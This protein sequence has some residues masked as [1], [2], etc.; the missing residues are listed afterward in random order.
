[1]TLISLNLVEFHV[2]RLPNFE[3]L[4]NAVKQVD[5]SQNNCVINKIVENP[6]LYSSCKLPYERIRFLNSLFNNV[7]LKCESSSFRDILPLPK[8]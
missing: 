4:S 5:N 2:K 1:M 6:F 7:L 8:G 3:N